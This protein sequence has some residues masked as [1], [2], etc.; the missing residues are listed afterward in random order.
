VLQLNH[1]VPA[2]CTA[3][4]SQST[5]PGAHT[6]NRRSGGLSTAGRSSTASRYCRNAAEVKNSEPRKNVT[7]VARNPTASE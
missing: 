1:K 2:N 3:Q 6:Q 4:A 5:F 7:A